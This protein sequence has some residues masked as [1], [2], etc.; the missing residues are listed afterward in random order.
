MNVQPNLVRWIYQRLADDALLQEHVVNPQTQELRIYEAQGP[1]RRERVPGWVPQEP[2]NPVYPLVRFQILDAPATST[3]GSVRSLTTPL[4]RIEGVDN[5]ESLTALEA[6]AARIEALFGTRI[7]G[8][9]GALRIGGAVVV[10]D[11]NA[12]ETVE[13]TV[14]KRLGLEATF[15]CY[16]AQPG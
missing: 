14:Y 9:Q 11:I 16:T 4:V 13:Q 3:N 8:S 1:V 15:Y 10:R 2:T 12:T 5:D 6:I 7:M